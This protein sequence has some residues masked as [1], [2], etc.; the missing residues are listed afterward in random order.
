MAERLYPIHKDR[1]HPS[2]GGKVRFMVSS[3]GYVMVRRPRAAPYVM[4]EKAWLRLPFYEERSH[5]H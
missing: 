1:A 3:G 2:D 4:P 5:D